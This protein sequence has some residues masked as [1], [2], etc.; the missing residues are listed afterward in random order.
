MYTTVRSKQFNKSLKKISKHKDFNYETLISVLEQLEN[1]ILLSPRHRDHALKGDMSGIRECHIQ[2][3]ILLMYRKE[4]D[5]L[6]LLLVDIG[7][8]SELFG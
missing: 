4:K 6:I 1:N 2:N 3:D 5:I 7:T 8:H